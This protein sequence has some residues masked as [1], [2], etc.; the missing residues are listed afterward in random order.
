[1]PGRLVEVLSTTGDRSALG[2]AG[3]CYI[4][5]VMLG[6]GV[7]GKPRGETMASVLII[8]DD[9]TTRALIGIALEEVGHLP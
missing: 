7:R 8:D 5:Q 2:P 3:L 4:G 1:M 9:Q 6:D